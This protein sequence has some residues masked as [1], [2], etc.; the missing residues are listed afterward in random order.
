M[1][2]TNEITILNYIQKIADLIPISLYWL[3]TNQK[4]LGASRTMLDILGATSYEKD[5]ANKTPY[6]I[7][8]K[9][10]AETIIMHHREVLQTGHTMIIEE[11]ITI[12]GTLGVMYCNAHISSLYDDKDNTI[13]TIGVSVDATREKLLGHQG[14][15]DEI[16]KQLTKNIKAAN[17]EAL[18]L[19]LAIDNTSIIKTKNSELCTQIT[20]LPL[21]DSQKNAIMAIINEANHSNELVCDIL[22][23]LRHGLGNIDM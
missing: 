21:E 8:P 7:Y 22:N 15:G 23:N 5:F 12:P 19:L 4:Y 6:D 3:D 14:I 11:A 9:E 10:Q 13:G 18:K 17:M 20:K 16:M 1:S 2:T